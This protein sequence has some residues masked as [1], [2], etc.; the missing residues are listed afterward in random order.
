MGDELIEHGDPGQQLADLG[1][2]AAGI[3]RAARELLGR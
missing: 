3:E 1:L 2:D